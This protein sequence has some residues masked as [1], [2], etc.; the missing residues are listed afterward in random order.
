MSVLDK[1]NIAEFR[2]I[3]H[4]VFIAYIPTGDETSKRT[5][6]TLATR[7]HD[8]YTFGLTSDASLIKSASTTI[9]SITCINSLG[10]EQEILSGEAGLDAMEKFMEAATAPVIGE[11]TMRNELKYMKVTNP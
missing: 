11:F 2:A 4:F 5:F 3:D 8:K 1:S 7:H 10:G 6:T 9:P